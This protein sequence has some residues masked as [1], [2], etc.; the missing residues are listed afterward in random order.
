[1]M[2]GDLTTDHLLTISTPVK[3]INRIQINCEH[4]IRWVVM[5]SH[6][7]VGGGRKKVNHEHFRT[8]DKVNLLGGKCA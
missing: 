7:S 3:C 2:D 8:H 6:Y 1:M 5:Q 4:G